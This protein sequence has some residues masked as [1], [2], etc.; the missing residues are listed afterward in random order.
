MFSLSESQV[1]AQARKIPEG[2]SAL[3]FRKFRSISLN[4]SIDVPRVGLSK[5]TMS[6]LGTES[7]WLSAFK[8]SSMPHLMI[9][10][11]SLQSPL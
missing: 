3:T 5:R 6:L 4:S 1:A 11:L 8:A 7:G 2:P 9:T 10:S